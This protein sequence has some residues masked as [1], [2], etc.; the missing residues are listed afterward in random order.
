MKK[1]CVFFAFLCFV[2]LFPAKIFADSNFKTAVDITYTVL[3]TGTT[4]ISGTG[5]LTNETD[6]YYA[7]SYAMQFGF[8]DLSNVAA[9]DKGGKITPKIEK[10]DTSTKVTLTFNR[11]A[12]GLYNTTTF[13]FSFDTNQVA[14]AVGNT[15]EI[16]I[17]G[18]ANQADYESFT[19]HLRVPSSFG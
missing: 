19:T 7:G 4:H 16:N 6:N 13:S 15:W 17:P 10:K 8:T 9:T 18:L 2:L 3:S 5:E 1:L 14:H 12:T 11:P